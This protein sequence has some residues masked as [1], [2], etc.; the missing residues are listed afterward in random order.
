MAVYEHGLARRHSSQLVGR[1]EAPE[2]DRRGPCPAAVTL[3]EREGVLT[4]GVLARKAGYEIERRKIGY[5][6]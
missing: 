5:A 2:S 4:N 3:I 1:G 6:G